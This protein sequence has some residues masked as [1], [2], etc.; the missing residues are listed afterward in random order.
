ML[1]E[2]LPCRPLAFERGDRGG[3]RCRFL[4]DQI[5][6]GSVGLELFELELHLIEQA[7][8]ALGAGA[9]LLALQLGDLQ[10]EVG[11]QRLDGA[12]VGHGVGEPGLCLISLAGHRRHKRLERFNVVRK[13]RDGGFHDAE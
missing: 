9:I 10:L 5:V 12:L 11:D 7:S 6:F 13:G 2:R 8:A 1:G 3:L 4:G